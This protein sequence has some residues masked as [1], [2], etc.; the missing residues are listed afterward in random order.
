MDGLK[1]QACKAVSMLSIRTVKIVVLWVVLSLAACSAPASLPTPT[2]VSMPTLPAAGKPLLKTAAGEFEVAAARFTEEV[3]G[4]KPGPEEKILLV[5]LAQPGGKKLDPQAFSLEAF[6][7]A[8]QDT[9]QGQVHILGDDGSFTISS[10]AGW[11]EDEFAM[12]FRLPAAAKT[13]TLFWPGNDP[14]V[15]A[16]EE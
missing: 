8:L 4:V 16:P 5:I 7:Q 12:G 9:G 6:Q 14:I 11:V 15:L 10:M 1:K 3:H 13:Y 2:N